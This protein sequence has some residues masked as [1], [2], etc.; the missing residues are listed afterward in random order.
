MN[1]YLGPGAQYG[2]VSGQN[3]QYQQMG[4]PPPSSRT[5]FVILAQVVIVQNPQQP[6]VVAQRTYFYI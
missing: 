4:P 6:R 5:Y 1:N 2:T 3:Y